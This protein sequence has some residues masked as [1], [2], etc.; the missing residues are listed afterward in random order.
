MG[1]VHPSNQWE[2]NANTDSSMLTSLLLAAIAQALSNVQ[3]SSGA[4]RQPEMMLPWFQAE[5]WELFLHIPFVGTC[6][7]RALRAPLIRL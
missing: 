4:C 5:D 6:L 3:G 2:E 1:Q 7:Q